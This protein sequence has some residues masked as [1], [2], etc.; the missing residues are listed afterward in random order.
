MSKLQMSYTK[1]IFVLPIFV[2]LAGVAVYPL[3]KLGMVSL[4]IGMIGAESSRGIANYT[5]ALHDPFFWNSMRITTLFVVIAVS[6]Q[7]GI[8]LGLALL[9]QRLKSGVLRAVLLFPMMIS[10]I[11]VGM[12]W[13]IMYH[14]MFGIINQVLQFFRLDPQGWLADPK[15]ALPS[16]IISDIWQW[17]AF[18]YLVLLAG[19][20]SIPEEYYE[21]AQLDGATKWQTFRHITFPLLKATV[22]I[23]LLFRT[24]S[25]FKVFGKFVTLTSGGPGRVT[26]VLA[27]YIY[28]TSFQYMEIGYGAALA[29]LAA[30]FIIIFNESYTHLFSLR[31]G[32]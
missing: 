11:A 10:P 30:L 17:T 5:K 16:V 13:R 2:L 7:F 21:A 32:G 28:K 14:P 1:W 3:V 6:I 27:L 29:V 31:K 9:T 15:L 8:G 26:E 25:A 4:S 19:L 18:I 12:V 22:Y 23:A 24:L 20:Q